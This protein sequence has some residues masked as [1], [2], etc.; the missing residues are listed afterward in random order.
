MLGRVATVSRS[1]MTNLVR[2]SH[3]HGGIPGENLPFSLGNRY[4]MTAMFIAF[5]GSGLGLPFFVLRH[6]LLKM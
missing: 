3:S 2:Y 4:K 1:G 6:Q 5:F